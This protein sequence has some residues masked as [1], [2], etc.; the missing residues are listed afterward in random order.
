MSREHAEQFHAHLS[1]DS[2]LR[3]K[4]AAASAQI[5]DIARE[6]GMEFTRDELVQ[7]FKD[8]FDDSTDSD[9]GADPLSSIASER[10]GR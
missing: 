1:Q 3:D 10:P 8:K 5:I 4:V 2:E 6:H 7:V 9:D